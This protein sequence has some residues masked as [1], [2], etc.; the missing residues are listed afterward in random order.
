MILAGDIGGTKTFLGLFDP[1][2]GRPAPLLV[3]EFA[4][5]SFPD[6]TTMVEAFANEPKVHGAMVDSAA[7]GI[8]GPVLG[9]TAVLTNVPFQIDAPAIATTFNIPRVTLLNDLEAMAH[10]VP[11]LIDDELHALQEGRTDEAGNV[12]LI[13]AGTGLGESLL[14][15]IGGRL[16][17]SPTEAGH[18]DWAARNDR[19]IA[20]LQGLIE[21]FGRAEVEQVVS[22]PGL[23]NLHRL[24]HER[25][26]RAAIDAALP[27]AAA[28]ISKAA[29]ERRCD[30]CVE[31]LSIFVDAYGAEAGNLA[32]RSVATGGVYIGGGI[33]P[34]ILPALTDGRFM[35]AFQH[36]E[37]FRAMMADI[38]VRIIL[39]ADAGLLGAAHV[40]ATTR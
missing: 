12:A 16:V 26:C 28:L 22:G 30:G 9:D 2:H 15:N 34:K 3:R 19:E 10:A 36:K 13:A 4:T 39:I 25:S 33:A 6:L 38:P 32:L 23:A 18:A 31:A 7:F 5:L 35:R 37:P 21:R 24:T 17:P 14:H 11:L 1:R 40:A 27:G 20:V 29:L 8:A